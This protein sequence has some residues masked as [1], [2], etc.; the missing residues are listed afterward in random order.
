MISLKSKREIDLI[1]EAGH[2]NYL[3][4]RELEK[5]LKPG[6]TT[7][8]LNNIADKFIRK[9]GG[10]P[11]CLNYEGY[12]KSIC[13]SV[14]DEVVHGIPSNRKIKSGDVVSFDFCTEYK[15]Y[16]ADSAE[17]HIVGDVS[18]DTKDLV[19]N[20]KKA[21]YEGLSV[22]KDG[23]Y[24]KDIGAAIEDYAHN[25]GL[26]VVE[27][28]VGHGI[29]TSIHEAPDVPNYRNDSSVILKEGM[30]I[31]VEPMLNLGKRY[32]YMEDDNWTIKTQDKKPSAHFEH[33]IVVT[34]DGYE[35][36]TGE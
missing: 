35:V 21:L 18:D 5:H 6:V 16:N 9:M 4:H 26:S 31:A 22:I 36:L 17:T 24:L 13:I 29:G 30:V 7:N 10:K 28:L 34:K 11:S 8:E 32:V 19:E 15:G 14:N 2:I 1:K 20:T 23:V 27:E 3:T 25:H 12:P 33:T